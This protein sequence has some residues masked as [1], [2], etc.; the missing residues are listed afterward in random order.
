[1]PLTT[2][3]P[4]T[5]QALHEALFEDS[6]DETINCHRSRYAFRGLS[7]QS[8]ELATSLMRLSGSFVTL[9]SHLLRNFK[10][11]AHRSMV[12]K[13]SL[14]H[15]LTMAQHHGLPTRL[16]DWA[17]SPYV[18]LHFA[19][20]DLQRYDVDGV[21]WKVNYADAHKTLPEV[22]R[23]ALALQGGFVFT[24]ETLASAIPTLDDLDELSNPETDYAIF[25]EPPSVDERIVNQF[26]YFSVLTNPELSM[27]TWLNSTTA[28]SVKIVVWKELKWEIRDKLDQCNITERVLFPGLDGL[29]RWLARHYSPRAKTNKNQVPAQGRALAY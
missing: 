4:D 17:Y 16:L 5:W 2:I 28:P 20:A 10:K 21:V 25:F 27:N 1:M 13:D 23:D 9:E 22:I 24:T 7:D 12:E 8:Y 26:A 6:W 29:C 18:A 19:T 14:W 11:Y 3:E 15:W